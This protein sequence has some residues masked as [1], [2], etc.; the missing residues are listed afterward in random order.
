[1][2]TLSHKVLAL[3]TALDGAEIPHA[4]G[5]ALA[6]AFHVQEPRATRDIDLNIFVPSERVREVFGVLPVGISRDERAERLIRDEGQVR[7]LW[8]DNPVDL[9]FSTHA[10]HEEAAGRTV[11]VPFEGVAIPILG[12]TELVVFKALFGRPKD[13][14]DIESMLDAGTVDV[15]RVLGWLVDL[16]GSDDARIERFRTLLDRP[17]PGPEPNFRQIIESRR[18]EPAH[19][20]A[21]GDGADASA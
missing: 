20:A 15:H 14:V 3:E 4:F 5:G 1:M 16:R 10:F 11:D 13:W 17:P 21:P 12:A 19:D 2:S 7:L 18:A 6:L 9:F 8:G